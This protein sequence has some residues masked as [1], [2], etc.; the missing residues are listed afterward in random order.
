LKADAFVRELA[1]KQEP[2]SLDVICTINRILRQ[3]TE[4]AEIEGLRDSAIAS[5]GMS[6]LEYPPYQI[7][8][9]E[10]KK[11]I[12]WINEEVKK[13]R[14][15]KANPIEIGALAS[16]R[17]VSFHPFLDAN[18]RTCR[19]IMDYILQT[20]N[21]PPPVLGNDVKW[22]LFGDQDVPD[23]EEAS[24]TPTKAVQAIM[25]GVKK[26]YVLLESENTVRFIV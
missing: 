16:Q 26:S 20:C 5:G 19:F 1:I 6:G 24:K 3:D 7:L 4:D 14:E 2:L 11:L 15:G 18:G 25:E 10:M 9:E 23:T 17:A 21:L 12:N 13:C 8:D 22:A